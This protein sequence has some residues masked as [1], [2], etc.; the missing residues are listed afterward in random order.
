[1]TD[2]SG[3]RS[4]AVHGCAVLEVLDAHTVQQLRD[5]V[6]DHV[7]RTAS[8]LLVPSEQTHPELPLERRLQAIASADRGVAETLLH[9]VCSDAQ[10]DPRIASLAGH[11]AL[12]ETA[13]RLAGAPLSEPTIRVRANV[14]ALPHRRQ[15]WHSDVA[16]QDGSACSRVRVTCWIPLSAV[17][18]DNGSLEVALGARS[19]PPPNRPR[20]DGGF[21]VLPEALTGPREVVCGAPGTVAFVAP[22]TPHRAL[23]S[24]T[25]TVR[26]SVVCW[27]HGEEVA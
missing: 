19:A 25:E 22:F 21:E 4:F 23:P 15:G 3:Q 7:G 26:W 27:F 20:G 2:L 10:R 11:P 17:G 14:P 12:R 8:A 13:Q 18:A 5:A 1:M 6:D 24:T 9:A 16:V